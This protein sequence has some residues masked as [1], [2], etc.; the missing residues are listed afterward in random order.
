MG[1][2]P[3]LFS[4]IIAL[5]QVISENCSDPVFLA[6]DRLLSGS[7][8]DAC[9]VEDVISVQTAAVPVGLIKRHEIWLTFLDVR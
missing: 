8:A 1:F 6:V 5:L 3:L 4:L 2:F 7:V 9:S